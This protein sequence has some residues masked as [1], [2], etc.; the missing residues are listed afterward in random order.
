MLTCYVGLQVVLLSVWMFNNAN[1]FNR[2][3][4]IVLRRYVFKR[5][6]VEKDLSADDV[7]M[8]NVTNIFN[9]K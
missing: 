4:L 7:V 3:S 2:D 6:N 9:N 1:P 8:S 5:R